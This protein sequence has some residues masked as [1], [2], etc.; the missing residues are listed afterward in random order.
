MVNLSD[1]ILSNTSNAIIIAFNVI[2]DKKA[3]NEAK[4]K[5]IKIKSYNIIYKIF[6][7]NKKLILNKII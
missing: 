1:I 5:N 6:K 3:K 7:R 2:I 4:Q